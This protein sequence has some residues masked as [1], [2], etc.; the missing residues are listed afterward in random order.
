MRKWIKKNIGHPLRSYVIQG[1][2]RR[3]GRRLKAILYIGLVRINVV[4]VN[5]KICIA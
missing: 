3:C 5:P 1:N 4:F 2:L